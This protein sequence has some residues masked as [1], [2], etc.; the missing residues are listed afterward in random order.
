MASKYC[1]TACCQ[2][3]PP[4]VHVTWHKCGIIDL[5]SLALLAYNSYANITASEQMFMGC[6]TYPHHMTVVGIMAQL[7][8]KASIDCLPG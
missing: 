5:K 3:L 6:L 4:I 2:T 1:E 7:P 8:S